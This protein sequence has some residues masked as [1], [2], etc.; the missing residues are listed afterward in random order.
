MSSGV[1]LLIGVII[2]IF[3]PF[4]AR[5]IYEWWM[6]PR[7]DIQE[8]EPQEG[9]G[10][11]RHSIRIANNGRTVAKNCNVILTIKGVVKDDIIKDLLGRTYVQKDNYRPIKDEF[12]CWSFQIRNP[13]G[14][15]INPAFLS[16]S[17]K[18]TRLVELCVFHRDSLEL[19]VPSEMG[20]EIRRVILRGNKE[21]EV[22]LKIFAENVQYD[23]KKHSK[24]FKLTPNI[25]EKDIVVK[26]LNS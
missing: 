11:V 15:P 17:P 20:W 10:F 19:E 22:E 6:K 3:G 16:I 24:R 14:N 8:D 5:F 26:P 9:E 18:S 25:K 1:W 2:G 7:M 13:T 23:P 4:G 12:L 21:Y